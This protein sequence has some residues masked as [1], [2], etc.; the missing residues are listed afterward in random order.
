MNAPP[1][2]I[3]WTLPMAPWCNSSRM[4]STAGRNRVHIASMR[5]TPRARASA[6]QLIRLA[7]V[8][9]ERL[10]AEHGF[11][12]LEAGADIGHVGDGGVAM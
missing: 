11:A 8:Q 6:Y 5:N 2:T 3:I 7:G 4:A 12:L 9:R 10:F 1:P